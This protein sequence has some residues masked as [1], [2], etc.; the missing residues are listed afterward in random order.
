MS[1]KL[2]QQEI[3]YIKYAI[4]NQFLTD[5]KWLLDMFLFIPEKEYEDKYIA[6]R[7]NTLFVK[8]N[9]N[10]KED[11]IIFKEKYGEALFN[12]K[13]ELSIPKKWLP[14]LNKDITT[15]I[16]RV[17]VNYILLVFN[18]NDKIDYINGTITVEDI[19]NLIKI[20]LSDEPKNDEI[21]VQEYRN[22]IKAVTFIN[23][24]SNYFNLTSTNKS[25]LPAPG[26]DEFRKKLIKKYEEQYG[27]E[28]LMSD[29][30]II[31]KME[32]ELEDYDNKY[33]E[34]DPTVG[35]LLSGK[36]KNIARKKLYVMFGIGNS[37]TG[38]AKPIT[39][40]LSDG[41]KKDASDLT[42]FFNDARGGS[43][44]RGAETQQGGV[45]AKD[46]LKA[47]SDIKILKTDCKTKVYIKI[48]ITAENMSNYIG[49][50]IVVNNKIVT[51]TIDNIKDYIN[52]TVNLRSPLTCKLA[53]YFCDTCM[54][55]DMSGY[56]NGMS[57][58]A[59]GIGGTM[60]NESLKKFHGGNVQILAL[61]MDIFK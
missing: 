19:E 5:A 12:F 22:F 6:I 20:K 45:V 53:P 43:F 39:Y 27:K 21:S 23:G 60:L 17:I 58:I 10:G 37:V 40:S 38:K 61:D 34:N 31:V 8:I 3:D 16:G 2:T 42:T 18:F 49:R 47:T 54:N 52:K 1:R 7:N 15:T 26:I 9:N 56:E 11:D 46:T 25:I 13:D 55:K 50:N 57:L 14:N 24:F 30:T 36:V 33:L 48:K 51:L 4:D 32:K 28:K 35:K 59:S 41:W 44:A 29:P